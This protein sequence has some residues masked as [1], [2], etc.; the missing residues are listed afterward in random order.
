[1]NVEHGG[2]QPRRNNGKVRTRL[3]PPVRG[4]DR[5]RASPPP[6]VS[7]RSKISPFLQLREQQQQQ[8]QRAELVKQQR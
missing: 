4:G 5:V 1:M 8:Q 6:L 2:H 7:R 3:T